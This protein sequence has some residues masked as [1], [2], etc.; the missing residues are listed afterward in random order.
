MA[1]DTPHPSDPLG[2]IRRER[3]RARAL[4]DPNADLCCLATSDAG[5]HPALRMLVLREVTE[6]SL[7]VFFSRSS[8]KFEHLASSG[9][10]EL[11]LFWPSIKRQ[12]R[13]RGTHEEIASEEIRANWLRRPRGS[14]LLDHYHARVAPQS[15]PVPSRDELL[16]GMTRLEAELTD[17]SDP[18]EELPFP[19]TATGFRLVP[20]RIESWAESPDRVHDRR[21]WTLVEGVWTVQTLVP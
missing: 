5:G 6:R 17:E 20:H 11:L 10:W 9:R 8:P 18:S 21:L 12:F 15:T 4:G 16:A 19:S 2:E 14:Q 13:L 1:S 7:A 3:E